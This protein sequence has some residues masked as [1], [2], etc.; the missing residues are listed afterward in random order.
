MYTMEY[1]ADNDQVYNVEF[2]FTPGEYGTRDEYGAP[3]EPD[4]EDTVEI[5]AGSSA[6]TGEH[7]DALDF[8][9]ENPDVFNQAFDHLLTVKEGHDY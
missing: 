2:T 3:L 7:V 5:E 1:L 4:T 9:R 6:A 8:C